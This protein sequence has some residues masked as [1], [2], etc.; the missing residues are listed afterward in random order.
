MLGADGPRQLHASRLDDHAH[1][2]GHAHVTVNRRLNRMGFNSGD[3]TPPVCFQI[4]GGYLLQRPRDRCATVAK[5]RSCIMQEQT[6]TSIDR[7]TVP[8][9]TCS[10]IMQERIMTASRSTNGTGQNLFLHNAR[11]N[12][13][14]RLLS[15]CTAL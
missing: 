2:I 14:A 9:K 12:V 3:Q 15:T 8:A 7:P 1:K 13:N 10:C 6:K 11:T 4:R 5:T